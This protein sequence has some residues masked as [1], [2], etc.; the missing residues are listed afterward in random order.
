VHDGTF[1]LD[2]HTTLAVDPDLA[3]VGHWWRA[4][5]GPATGCWLP[6]GPPGLSLQ[7][8]PQL[9]RE[10][11]ALSVTPAAVRLRGGDAAG[12]RYGLQTLRQ[13]LPPAA[14]AR[15][16]VRSEQ[17]RI[18]CVS[19]EDQPRF[20]W[21]GCLLDVARHFLPK[22]D[23]LRFI[24]LLAMHKLN[25]LHL[26]LTD[27][28][29]W[30]L[31]VPGWPR[32]T[33]VGAWRRESP[34]GHYRHQSSDG[35]PH[36]G[37]YMREELAEIVAYAA[38]RSVTVVPEVDLPGHVQAAVAAYPELGGPEP[39]EVRTIWGISK[40][41]LNL[42]D[43]ALAFCRDVLDEI[44]SIFPSPYISIGGDECPT[45]EWKTGP[46]A[47]ARLRAEDLADVA[48][49][50]P[51]FTARMAEQ[52]AGHGRTLFG[53]DELLDGGAPAGTTI[54]AWRGPQATLAA[55]RAGHDVVACPNTAV[56]LDYR[57]STHPG[58]P[59]P[60]GSLLTLEDVYAFD[61][62]PADLTPAEAARV[63]GVESC[64]WTEYMDSARAVDY[65][66]FP[67]LCALAE[68]AWSGPGRPEADFAGRL[69][70]HMGRLR[71]YGVEYRD[72]TGPLPWQA[73]P[74]ARGWPR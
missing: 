74:D 11:Y 62:V 69:R 4:T 67:R 7:L 63:I 47:Q 34:I 31:P 61:P 72:D 10:A 22:A 64:V 21:R 52:L 66:A 32:L 8:D 65:M 46:A 17:W 48:D 13:L 57:Q 35:R 14:Y 36:G 45:D 41:V 20:A 68:V 58:E 60:V 9:G 1:V 70:V 30:R 33:E 12:V 2:E 6:A 3:D 39:V 19:I 71:A 25:V 40:H 53:W 59:T 27:D 56:Y 42:S 23:V 54:A 38:D 44:V 18:P 28:Q 24:D 29:G 43:R 16:R 26:H 51:W 73:R 5:V 50:Q 37:F 49:L 55:A 15:A